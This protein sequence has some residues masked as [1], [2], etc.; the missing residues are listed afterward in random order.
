VT[1]NA[2]RWGCPDWRESKSYPVDADSLEDGQWKWEFIRRLPAYRAFYEANKTPDEQPCRPSGN[3]AHLLLYNFGLCVIVNPAAPAP[4]KGYYPFA[5][6]GGGLLYLPKWKDLVSQILSAPVEQQLDLA[7]RNLEPL[8]S[9]FD[10][11]D[12]GISLVLIDVSKP[13]SPQLGAAKLRLENRAS[14]L[15]Q[16]IVVFKNRREHW[17]RHLRVIDA[18][19]QGA[20]FAEIADQFVEDGTVEESTIYC[21]RGNKATQDTRHKALPKQWHVQAVEVMEKAARFL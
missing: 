16:D 19:D 20:T 3:L 13:I 2:D 6:M 15:Y 7:L 11:V 10:R 12:D 5:K 21:R 18:R 14:E 17:V 4:P 9:I 1:R 8:W